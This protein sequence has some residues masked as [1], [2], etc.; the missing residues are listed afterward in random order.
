MKRRILCAVM[1]LIM[2]LGMI[3]VSAVSA[4]ET[5]YTDVPEKHWAAESIRRA[6]ELGVF[7]GVS[8]NTFGLGQSINRAAFVTAL[9]RLFGWETVESEKATF[10]D[11]VKGKWY[12]EAVETAVKNGAVVAS[13]KTFRP[14]DPL[15]R[16]DMASMIMRALGYTS[17][18]GTV[19]GYESPFTDVTT[20]K[21]FITMAYDMGIVGG[22]GNSKFDPNGTATRE[23]AA[24]ILVR[25]YDKLTA[26]NEKLT[27][28]GPAPQI[29]IKTPEV[30][31]GSELPAT[32]LEPIGDL[33]AALREMKESGEDMSRVVL[34][35]TAGGVRT[36]QSKQ[37]R[38][39]SVDTITAG[40][41]RDILARNGV[42][43]YYSER[44]ESAY[45]VHEPNGYQT[46]TIWYQSEE[47]LAVKLQLG[48]MFGVT[49]Y[50]LE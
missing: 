46:V 26:K 4:V 18:A 43:T 45:C 16:G 47:S 29:T 22:V 23:Q 39:L 32:P 40:Q 38:I 12:Y 44:Y 34:R 21:G 37:G 8:G 9:V 13:G 6:T 50:S 15:T 41:V 20:N 24:A 3:P 10:T 25:V 36:T 27:V 7:N 5:G 19:S 49:K 28:A 33:Y 2:C 1:A 42:R 31:E 48:R 30:V 11:V 17:L 35:L 14:T